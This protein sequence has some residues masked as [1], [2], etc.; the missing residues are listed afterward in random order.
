[1]AAEHM[2][3]TLARRLLATLSP[4]AHAQPR[5]GLRSLADH[6]ARQRPLRALW[7]LALVGLTCSFLSACGFVKNEKGVTYSAQNGAQA[8]GTAAL[9]AT[10]HPVVVLGDGTDAIVLTRARVG[11][12]PTKPVQQFVQAYDLAAGPQRSPVALAGPTASTFVASGRPDVSGHNDSLAISPRGRLATIWLGE[13]SGRMDIF[14]NVGSSDSLGGRVTLATGLTGATPKRIAVALDRA[15]AV[16][17]TPTEIQARVWENATG[18]GDLRRIPATEVAGDGRLGDAAI[19]DSTAWVVWSGDAVSVS[20]YRN[21][22]WEAPVRIGTAAGDQVPRVAWNPAAVGAEPVFVWRAADGLRYNRI[23]P[24]GSL[25]HADGAL[26]AGAEGVTS[27]ATMTMSAN[28]DVM[29]LFNGPGGASR[30]SNGVWSP[31]PLAV[32]GSLRVASDARGNAVVAA[33]LPP[34]VA[35]QRYIAGSGWQPAEVLAE[36]LL[37]DGAPDVA[38]DSGGRAIVVWEGPD[39]D[40][41]KQSNTRVF[42]RTIGV[43]SAS[44]TVTPNPAVAGMPVTF[45][46]S[47]S[48]DPGGRSLGYSWVFGDSSGAATA[49][50]TH[51]FASPGTYTVRLVVTD[52]IGFT[53]AAEKVVTVNAAATGGNL[54]INPDFA[55]AVDVGTLPTGPGNWRGDVAF[56][57]PAE[58]GISPLSAPQMLKFVATGNVSSTNTVASQQWQ[59]VDM[60]AFGALIAAGR[61][62]ADA[63]VWFNRV[64]GTAST[65]R[66][67]DLRILAFDGPASELP[68]R[69]AANSWLAE[70]TTSVTTGGAQWQQAL[71]SLVLPP[72]TR[73][74]LFE[75]YA[76]EDVSNEGTTMEFDGHYADDAA[77]VVTALPN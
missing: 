12:D 72:G 17:R 77:L 59:I 49:V 51:S 28:G 76:F 32:G 25:E 67:F 36:N 52:D 4:E 22:Q 55:A 39:P 23:L 5:C 73:Y 1:M 34:R 46:G 54:L 21:G 63:S 7:G 65:D 47:S 70:Q 68:A 26:I 31:A 42:T 45:D 24:N 64:V 74:L 16:W 71:A 6:A 57:V 69:F 15:L 43:P 10:R 61:A 75:I 11:E 8:D 62:R 9:V 48:S 56:A 66:R 33:G 53:S 27:D 18:W 13:E 2:L 37:P 58:N 20:R 60:S 38:M 3:K 40:P 29:L 30:Y 14:A 41:A 35:I 19:G 50:A 44:F